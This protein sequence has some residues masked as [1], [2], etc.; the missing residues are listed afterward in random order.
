MSS[1][2]V[3]SGP[4][5]SDKKFK[6][7]QVKE[8]VANMP[9]EEQQRRALPVLARM[10]VNVAHRVGE[11]LGQPGIDL[12]HEAAQRLGK[13][14]GVDL[15][16]R[17]I[18]LT[19][20]DYQEL[21]RAVAGTHDLNILDPVKMTRTFQAV[22]GLLMGLSC[23]VLVKFGDERGQSIVEQAWEEVARQRMYWDV[24]A[25]QFDV[26][27][28]DAGTAIGMLAG[29][30]AFFGVQFDVGRM[31]PGYAERNITFCTPTA[32]AERMGYSHEVVRKFC[33]VVATSVCIRGVESMLPGLKVKYL[34]RLEFGDPSC[35]EV[36]IYDPK[37]VQTEKVTFPAENDGAVLERYHHR[38]FGGIPSV[39]QHFVT[40]EWQRIQQMRIYLALPEDQKKQ[41]MASALGA[42]PAVADLKEPRGDNSKTLLR[43]DALRWL[44]ARAAKAGGDEQKA[45]REL[46][47]YWAREFNQAV[48]SLDFPDKWKDTDAGRLFQDLKTTAAS[49]L[50][51]D[52]EKRDFPNATWDNAMRAYNSIF[53]LHTAMDELLFQTVG[54]SSRAVLTPAAPKPSPSKA[55]KKT[56]GKS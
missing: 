40:A 29:T 35:E 34:T 38:V 19:K 49:M 18:D 7:E 54:G 39:K 27:Q 44:A 28:M 3:Q 46:I 13:N 23:E 16:P 48:A 9:A 14:M 37:A 31:T 25:D 53:E 12:I 55:T 56:T 50:K 26:K 30:D 24:V 1:A 33:E 6:P 11:A 21:L 20:C 42:Q 5:K 47:S 51:F 15:P 4:W 2:K 41:A 36:A 45:L 22:G 32:V 17:T 10:T 52:K 43:V 8:A